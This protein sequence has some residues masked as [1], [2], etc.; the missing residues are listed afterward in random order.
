MAVWTVGMLPACF[1][2][3]RQLHSGW[4]SLS[5]S[6]HFICCGLFVSFICAFSSLL[7]SIFFGLILYCIFFFFFFFTFGNCAL[8][9]PDGGS[10]YLPN[11]YGG[12][13]KSHLMS[14][15]LFELFSIIRFH[16]GSEES[17]IE[18]SR[19]GSHF[20]HYYPGSNDM[21]KV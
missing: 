12:G 9:R 4:L 8:Y 10:R 1:L 20:Y 14:F 18:F 17:V 2:A 16:Y 5:A 11:S 15:F 6:A 13:Q 19:V 7:H 21:L 3:V